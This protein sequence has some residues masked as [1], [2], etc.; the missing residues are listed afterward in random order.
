MSQNILYVDA[1]INRNSSRTDRLAHMYLSR[2]GFDGSKITHRVL[3][4]YPIRMLN[5]SLLKFRNLMIEKKD[6]SD[7]LFDLAKEFS[8]ADEIIVAAPYWDLSFPAMLKCYLEQLSVNGIT[9]RIGG[10]GEFEGLC[11]A[12]RLIYIT[13]SGG[14]IGDCNYGFY[15]IRAL[16]RMFGIEETIC[17]K[18]EGLDI[19]G[20]DVNAVLQKVA[21]QF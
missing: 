11:K 16:C 18:A 14:Y 8:K 1:C 3:E 19:D 7:R 10:N 21:E 9:F 6:Y 20:V 2:C 13:S 5:G 12:K 15:Y 4:D 17:Y